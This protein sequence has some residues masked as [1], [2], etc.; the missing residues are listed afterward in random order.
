M[1]NV[2]C[3]VIHQAICKGFAAL[4]FNYLDN[5]LRI[6]LRFDFGR[7]KHCEDVSSGSG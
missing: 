2:L 1:L 3:F 7:N 6:I 4:L 5:N